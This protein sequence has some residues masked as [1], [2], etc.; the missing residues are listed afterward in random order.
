MSSFLI[1]AWTDVHKNIY[2]FNLCYFIDQ[3]FSSNLTNK[4]I[5]I[6]MQII[7]LKQLVISFQFSLWNIFNNDR[8]YS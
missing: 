2:K 5:I 7:I 1:Y 8:S 3:I 4:N 6:Q